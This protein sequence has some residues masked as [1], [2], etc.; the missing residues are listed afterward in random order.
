MGHRSSVRFHGVIFLQNTRL[1]QKILRCLQEQSVRVSLA[2]PATH[3][4]TGGFASITG[5]V[6][7]KAPCPS[8]I[9]TRT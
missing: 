4:S 7:A 3:F 8:R 5:W 9:R 2:Q 6:Q 1:G